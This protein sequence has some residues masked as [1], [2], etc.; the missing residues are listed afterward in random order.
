M[1]PG[2]GS[3]QDQAQQGPAP[4][5]AQDTPAALVKDLGTRFELELVEAAQLLSG[6]EPDRSS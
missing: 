6:L 1:I 2:A 3:D 5:A 4:P